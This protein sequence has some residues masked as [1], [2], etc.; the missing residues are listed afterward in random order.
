MKKTKNKSWFR[1]HWILTII[2]AIFL[3]GIFGA[4]ANQS[5]T[6]KINDS[7]INN[8]FIGE[9]IKTGMT[10]NSIRGL[11]N[12]VG[13]SKERIYNLSGFLDKDDK[14]VGIYAQIFYE[15]TIFVDEYL[16]VAFDSSDI[17]QILF[18]ENPDLV[19]IGI[20]F[21]KKDLDDYGNIQY[22]LLAETTMIRET[23]NKINWDNFERSSIPKITPFRYHGK[24]SIYKSL[25]DLDKSL[26]A[27]RDMGNFDESISNFNPCEELQQQCFTYQECEE[28]DIAKQAGVC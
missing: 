12:K 9:D 26:R 6:Q 14:I 15:K 8:S 19:A 25:I 5:E 1:R 13:I 27:Y 7:K 2:I 4:I 11:L 18:S 16:K 3:L 20:V 21:I 17:Y 28:I 24:N 10:S 23:Y 22:K